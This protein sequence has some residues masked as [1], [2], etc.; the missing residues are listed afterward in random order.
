MGSGRGVCSEE[1]IRKGPGP[2][3]PPVPAG[4]SSRTWDADWCSR[5]DIGECAVQCGGH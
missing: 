2:T 4:Q 1:L 3:P 5:T